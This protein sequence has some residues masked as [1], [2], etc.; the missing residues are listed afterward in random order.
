MNADGSIERLCMFTLFAQR[1]SIIKWADAEPGIY[2]YSVF[3]A[4]LQTSDTNPEIGRCIQ[5]GDRAR[6]KAASLPV[7]C[8]VQ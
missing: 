2:L 8:E 7:Y 4:Q 3:N 1:H 5:L 6:G